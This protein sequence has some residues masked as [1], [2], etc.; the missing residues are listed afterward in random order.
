MV[1]T[2]TRWDPATH[3]REQQQQ[4]QQQ[5][6]QGSRQGEEGLGRLVTVK[7][8]QAATVA[9]LQDAVSIAFG[10]PPE[11]QYLIHV[12]ATRGPE[13]LTRG[14][15]AAVAVAGGGGGGGGGID[16]DETAAA[17]VAAVE[18]AAAAS[19]RLRFGVFC[20]HEIILEE[21]KGEGD[22]G[23]GGDGGAAAARSDAMAT[24]EEEINMIT[25]QFNA[26][27]ATPSSVVYDFAVRVDRRHPLLALKKAIAEMLGLGGAAG[28]GAAGGGGGG[29]DG[30]DEEGALSQFHLRR[31]PR[32][33]MLK[34]EEKT[35][36][37]LRFVDGSIVYVA[38]GR[39]LRE[40][41]VQI[42]VVQYMPPKASAGVGGR[43]S[44]TFKK[45]F[46][47][48]VQGKD[49]VKD[50]K[51][52]IAERMDSTAAKA[53]AKSSGGAAPTPP[54][55]DPACLRLQHRMQRGVGAIFRDDE[56]LQK[57][58]S[59]GGRMQDGKDVAVQVLAGPEALTSRDIVITARLWD[60][61]V[62]PSVLEDAPGTEIVV[63]KTL[64]VDEFRAVLAPRCATAAAAAAAA[65]A[66]GPDKPP[67]EG[68]GKGGEQA[69][70]RVSVAKPSKFGPLLTKN[71]A[72]KLKWDIPTP[73]APREAT[74]DDDDEQRAPPTAAQPDDPAAP[75]EQHYTEAGG[76]SSSSSSSS[77]ATT[78]TTAT[79]TATNT[80]PS[81]PLVRRNRI[82][83][84]P[85]RL[86]DGECILYRDEDAF[87]AFNAAMQERKKKA[88][89]EGRGG[90]GCPGRQA[91]ARRRRRRRRRRRSEKA[92]EVEQEGATTTNDAS[93]SAG[94]AAADVDPDNVSGAAAVAAAAAAAT[95]GD[96]AKTE[97]SFFTPVERTPN[98][99]PPPTD[100]Q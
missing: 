43:P 27:G 94:T 81:P 85:L 68:P 8:D 51:R 38:K 50:V 26:L 10:V 90:G 70:R 96:P 14:L 3:A 80:E 98:P 45:L 17:G 47:V 65:S 97:Q 36:D 35:L 58:L 30:D 9:Q 21:K 54:K 32:A 12:H 92:M 7:G 48:R 15:D 22:E 5:Q 77:T 18:A 49:L 39:V 87:V 79:N 33:P 62:T 66:K 74:H 29:D 93:T 95:A 24:L 76:S 55:M 88:A 46:R 1:V 60:L 100:G 82:G 91:P 84:F 75:A 42:G 44:P 40:G 16:E 73:A 64:T 23:D 56:K 83:D 99:S 34:D 71:A 6:Q 4:R 37:S 52:R 25:V 11:R 59:K 72:A 13:L 63:S 69:T 78:T 31:N 57:Y 2:V 41:E 89:A 19:I 61:T 28:A 20:G 86:A 67:E 53:A